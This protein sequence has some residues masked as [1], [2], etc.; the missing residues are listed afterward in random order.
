M[1][2]TKLFIP[3]VLALLALSACGGSEP[4]ETAA[5]PGVSARVETIAPVPVSDGYEAVGTIRAK[6]TSVLSSK[7]VGQVL[8][9]RLNRGIT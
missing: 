5:S 2:R 9:V 6:S 4:I 3:V 1:H 7:V 8:S